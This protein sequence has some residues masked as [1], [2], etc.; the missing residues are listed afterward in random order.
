MTGLFLLAGC[1]PDEP[2]SHTARVPQPSPV[3]DNYIVLTVPPEPLLDKMAQLYS[4]DDAE[5]S[6]LVNEFVENGH[7]ILPYVIRQLQEDNKLSPDLGKQITERIAQSPAVTVD[8]QRIISL[9][10]I[11]CYADIMC[12]RIEYPLRVAT[13]DYVKSNI[14][15]QGTKDALH[16]IRDSYR[17]GLPLDS[18]GDETGDFRGLLVKSMQGRLNAYANQLLGSIDSQSGSN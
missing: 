8:A 2:T 17:S 14:D 9:M 5:W 3:A 15:S 10:E 12:H 18:P 7:P 6:M 1:Q 16:W 4:P 11:A 13:L